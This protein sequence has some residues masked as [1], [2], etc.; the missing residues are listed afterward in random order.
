[1]RTIN[2]CFPVASIILICTLSAK[3]QFSIGFQFPGV[4]WNQNYGTDENGI[5]PGYYTPKSGSGIGIHGNYLLKPKLRLT[6]MFDFVGTGAVETDSSFTMGGSNYTI[7]KTASHP[8]NFTRI[9]LQYAFTRNFI[10]KGLTFYGDAGV[11]INS[12][13]YTVETGQKIY[14]PDGSAQYTK[15]KSETRNYNG[16]SISFGLGLE[17]TFT[18]RTHLYLDLR[19]ATGQQPYFSSNNVAAGNFLPDG[20][21]PPYSSLALGMRF[22]LGKKPG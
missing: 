14:R 4:T 1:M 16:N 8:A 9:D 18:Y 17:Y 5:R 20:F 15:S 10:E 22:T 13:S 19:F 2:R 3:A 21:N 12:Y 11:A 7:Y 6:L